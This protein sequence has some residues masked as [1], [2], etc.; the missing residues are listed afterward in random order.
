LIQVSK[1]PVYRTTDGGDD[2][3][4]EMITV[5]QV[6]DLALIKTVST[7]TPSPIALGDTVTFEITVFNQ[8]TLDAYDIEVNDYIPTG[9]LLADNAWTQTGSVASLLNEIPLIA[10]GAN[11]V[12]EITFTVDPNYQEISLTNNSEI[13]FASDSDGG[14]AA[15]DEDSVPN[16][17]TGATPDGSDDD[18]LDT[19]GGDDYDPATIG[20]EQI[21]DLALTKIFDT[22]LDADGDGQVTA[23][24]TV[25]FNITVY[26]Q[27]S[28]M[29]DSVAITDYVPANLIYPATA[30]INIANGWNATPT[31]IIEDLASGAS[32]TVQ[33]AMII[34][35][36]FQGT[37][38]INDAEITE[39]TNEFG[40]PDEDSTPND[41]DGSTS[42]A[43]DND[44][45]DTDGG[46]DYDPAEVTVTQSFDLALIKTID[47]TATPGP[48]AQGDTV[49]F[50][51]EV[52]N[53]G[54]IDAYD[55]EISDYIPV[56][57][58]L[59]DA[60]W[61]DNDND[62][63]AELLTPI[64]DILVSEGSE[65]VSITFVID[66]AF[67]GTSIENVAEI[68]FAT[69]EDDSGI[70]TSDEDSDPDG[71]NDDPQG[72]DNTVD[73]SGG[74]EDDSDPAIITVDQVFDLALIKTVNSS[75][76][77]PIVPGGTVTFNI[78]V[79]NQGTIDAYDIN[80]N[81]YVP[82]GLSLA[83]TDWL[84]VGNVASLN[85]EILFL[86]A[87]EDVTIPITF[88]VDANFQGASITNNSEIE[89]AS[90]TDGGPMTID[91]DSSPNSE[92]GTTPDNFN[93]D[94]NDTTGNDDYDPE[95][96]PIEQ[97]FDLAL[98]KVYDSYIDSDNDG[99]ISAGDDVVFTITVYN[100]GTID[101][102]NVDIT[103]YVPADMSYDANLALNTNNGWGAGPNPTSTITAI[104][105]GA[106]ASVQIQLT[107]N[108]NFQGTS[109]LN[110][111]EITEAANDLNLTDEDSTPGD[112]SN[113]PSETD[114]DNDIS[115]DSN[116]GSDNTFDHDDF[117]FA[118][119]PVGQVFDLALTKVLD[120]SET[121]GPFTPGAAVTFTI[122]VF[123][124]GSLDAYDI[125]INEYIPEGLILTDG[126]WEDVTGN[127]IAQLL[128]PLSFLAAGDSE[129][130]DITFQIDQNFQGSSILNVAE[131]GYATEEE[132]SGVNANDIDSEA[133]GEDTDVISGDNT[134]DNGGGDEDDHDPAKIQVEQIFD[135]ALMKVINT[136]LTPAPYS[137]G[138]NVSYIITVFNQGTLDATN[139]IV[140]DYL[141]AG[142]IFNQ[143]DNNTFAFDNFGNL[144][145]TIAFIAAGDSE[146][147]SV[148]LQIDPNYQ[149]T[150]LVNDA[151]ITDATANIDADPTGTPATGT[152][153]VDSRPGNNELDDSEVDNDNVVVDIET[154]STQ[155]DDSFEDDF[156]LAIVNVDQ[157]FDLALIKQ[158]AT[159][160]EDLVMAGN[161]VTYTIT[162]YNQGTIDA[163][164]VI[165]QDYIPQDMTLVDADWNADGTYTIPF[166]AAGSNTTVDIDL[167][168]NASFEGTSITNFAEISEDGAGPEDIDSA[169]DGDDTN[170]G[171]VSND[172]TDNSAGDEDDHDL[173][174]I[175]VG[176]FDLALDKSLSVSQLDTVAIGD[177]IEYEIT[178]TNEGDFPSYNIEVLDHI[179]DG[180]ILSTQDNNNWTLETN[181][182]ASY[183]IAGPLNPGDDITLTI[184]LEILPTATNGSLR[185]V[186]EISNMTDDTGIVVEDE[187]SELE[188]DGFDELEIDF[189]DDE[190]AVGIFFNPCPQV[191][192]IPAIATICQG[193]SQPLAALGV[194]PNST[195]SW[196]GPT[197]TL[198]CTDCANPVATPTV[199]P[200]N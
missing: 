26:N 59:A 100:Q 49:T 153:D 183:I 107:I 32:T 185:N 139:V 24:D 36:A 157:V 133:D 120:V 193:A 162:V 190:D 127:G 47:A 35:P 38:I 29:A 42:D 137:A 187:D 164:N 28:I 54:T 8:G 11:Q 83:D 22:F 46:D 10:A 12:I 123:N 158:L 97:V 93:D 113:T 122:E 55:V 18:T 65:M 197:A 61:Q 87:G 16:D 23:G 130:I 142:L 45:D 174:V 163:T 125:Q 126:N 80:I 194:N 108:A 2:E 154:G 155:D 129:T 181:G 161:V 192:T 63:V 69:D 179:P 81:D 150:N 30:A 132:G 112:N 86:A 85:N 66:P 171:T 14:P 82:V 34:D 105:T 21:F 119:V 1:A 200:R 104:S 57:L 74:D 9:L 76:T 160:Q 44:I 134:I 116:G 115:D 62:G 27:G 110:D 102:S 53:Q 169:P 131:I 182:S 48:Y 3:D 98:T 70:N 172:I 25:L 52:F 114:S 6:F 111:A 128:S 50:S 198:S 90:S 165:I 7:T 146:D 189:E 67:Q 145:A 188:N 195:Y 173:E 51:I 166:L 88:V 89:S 79:Y 196:D 20:V 168:V 140:E 99:Q 64:A 138:D 124:Q 149:G 43:N 156:D 143:A 152:P 167:M 144:E 33:I 106:S 91:E 96:I 78:T 77:M 58:T 186:A 170:D 159:G 135:L 17:E 75:T 60:A 94:I 141:P 147:L 117:D 41:E 177:I 184:L 84:I 71:I 178:I 148:T 191:L 19:T 180:M 15:T 13:A 37:S 4:P 121:P 103:D 199:V 176:V 72:I 5:G 92:D 73:N 95:T 39:A 56:G 31:T 101:A 40:L 118:L 151:E 136:A 109:I 68:S 175:R